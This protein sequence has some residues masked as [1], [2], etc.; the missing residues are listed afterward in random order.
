MS[1]MIFLD[2]TAKL[3]GAQF[4]LLDI[5]S[6]FRDDC[7][8]LLLGDG[9]FRRL[10]EQ[11]DVEVDVFDMEATLSPLK[12]DVKIRSVLKVS[13]SLFAYLLRLRKVLLTKDIIYTNSLKSFIISALSI[14]GRRKK[15]VLHLRDALTEEHFSKNVIRA[16]L[17]MAKLSRAQIIANSLYTK[18]CFIEAGGNADRCQVIL[19]AIDESPF[20]NIEHIK[21]NNDFLKVLSLGRISPWKGQ[22][23]LIEAIKNIPSIELKIVGSPNFGE[24]E[25]YALLK[26]LVEKYGLTD[27]VSFV[28]FCI[29]IYE[30]LEWSDV[31]VHT[32]TS[33]EPFGRVVVEA[34]LA[35]RIA[36]ASDSGGVPEIIPSPYFG[37]RI[38]PGEPEILAEQLRKIAVDKKGY[39]AIA[40][41]GKVHAQEHFTLPILI[42][43][44]KEFFNNLKS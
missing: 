30:H 43:N 23:I 35:E 12:R 32:S 24:D 21:F 6:A 22:H 18:N 11:R 28:E 36:I 20:V 33:P 1:K 31:V 38:T 26:S 17:M 9:E 4:S 3:G 42:S 29:N 10:L 34:M 2:H 40:K 37:I 39:K 19:N 16:T 5:S 15:I 14:L 7:S 8:V 13:M 44:M 25:Y 41:N 27:R